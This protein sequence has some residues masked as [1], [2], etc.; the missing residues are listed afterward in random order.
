[1]HLHRPLCNQDQEEI[2]V[3]DEVL[4]AGVGQILWLISLSCCLVC[5]DI[6]YPILHLHVVPQVLREVPSVKGI[7]SILHWRGEHCS[8]RRIP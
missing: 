4:E 8:K 2:H 7:L 1:M 5:V 3:I 6:N